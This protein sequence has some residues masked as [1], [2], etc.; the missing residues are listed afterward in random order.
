MAAPKTTIKE[1]AKRLSPVVEN[2]LLSLYILREEQTNPVPSQ[3]A[4]YIRMLPA[5]EELGTSLPTILATLRRMSRDGLININSRKEIH[6]T[7]TGDRIASAITRRHRLAERLVVDIL[8]V[9]LSQADQEAHMLEHGITSFL[10]E[11]IR[12]AVNNPTTCPFGKPIP[13]SGYKPPT[14]SVLS[15]DKTKAGKKYLVKSIPDEDSRLVQYLSN[16]NLLPGNSIQILEIGD[17]RDVITFK[18]SSSE[19]ALGFGS[20]SRIY[21]VELN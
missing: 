1:N 20:A 4:A 12:K 6:L 10:E 2:Y 11:Y 3:L 7:P 17:Y 21:L 16:N 19:S 5:S 15:M 14:G 13:N 18:T 9:E 8:G